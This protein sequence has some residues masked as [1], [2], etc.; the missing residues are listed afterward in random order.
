MEEMEKAQAIE[1]ERAEVVLAVTTAA[2]E[3][4]E[5]RLF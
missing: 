5:M 3:G 4:G 2:S 1:K